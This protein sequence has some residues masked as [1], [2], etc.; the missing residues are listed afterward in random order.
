MPAKSSLN[1]IKLFKN[2]P[3]KLFSIW[4]SEGEEV[5]GKYLKVFCGFERRN[6][7]KIMKRKE[8]KEKGGNQKIY[9]KPQQRRFLGGEI[10]PHQLCWL[11]AGSRTTESKEG[12]CKYQTKTN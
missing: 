9:L 4:I 10:L 8:N 12:D 6:K 1:Y 11:F 5:L 2:N 7:N 3:L